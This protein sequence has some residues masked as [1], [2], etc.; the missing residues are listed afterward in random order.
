MKK[1]NMKKLFWVVVTFLVGFSLDVYAI[2]N[3]YYQ[4]DRGNLCSGDE[5]YPVYMMSHQM[6]SMFFLNYSQSYNLNFEDYYE[7]PFEDSPYDVK[8]GYLASTL[9]SHTSEYYTRS[10][11]RILWENLY[12]DKE[13]NLCGP[14]TW[15][16]KYY[17]EIRDSIYKLNTG[18]DFIKEIVYQDED[19]TYE[20]TSDYLDRFN[21]ISS[22]ENLSAKIENN[23]LKVAGKNGKYDL[24][25][26]RN[27]FSQKGSKLFT[28]GTNYLLWNPIVPNKEYVMHIV[29]GNSTKKHTVS[30]ENGELLKEICFEILE[31]KYCSDDNGI[32]QLDTYNEEYNIKLISHLDMFEP[33]WAKLHENENVILKL[34][35]IENFEEENNQQKEDK[36][37]D[38]FIVDNNTSFKEQVVIEVKDTFYLSKNL[39]YFLLFGGLFVLFKKS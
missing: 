35:K 32:I 25:F 1:G 26:K 33:Y 24:V 37:N 17:Y 3:T 10:I 13:F 7:I 5:T 6:R 21:I 20:Y 16:E 12:P 28:D 15:K 38:V 36:V 8:I 11:H 39:V 4:I 29:I 9:I 23:I 14:G 22:Y 30:N 18:P 27:D 34:K 31:S 19:K 2:D